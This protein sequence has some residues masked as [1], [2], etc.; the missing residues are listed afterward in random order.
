MNLGTYYL[1]KIFSWAVFLTSNKWL[2][3]I[4]ANTLWI[5]IFR[6][7]FNITRAPCSVFHLILKHL[8]SS[9]YFSHDINVPQSQ[10]LKDYFS[11]LQ[12]PLIW[13]LTSEYKM[14]NWYSDFVNDIG[15]STQGKTQ[16]TPN[17][18]TSISGKNSI[19][20]I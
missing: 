5:K 6:D 19:A 3:W 17:I 18:G 13:L 15:W 11:F 1:N 14:E 9:Y 10:I 12:D 7:Y 20:L 8:F 16:I 2:W 4:Y